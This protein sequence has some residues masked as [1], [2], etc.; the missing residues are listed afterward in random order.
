MSFDGR[1]LTEKVESNTKQVKIKHDDSQFG[2]MLDN[3]ELKLIR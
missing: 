2:K 3:T 1:M